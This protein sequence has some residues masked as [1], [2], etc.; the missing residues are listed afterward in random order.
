MVPFKIEFNVLKARSTVKARARDTPRPFDF[1]GTCRK[2]PDG[3][4][5]RLELDC[6]R[7]KRCTVPDFSNEIFTTCIV[8]T[9]ITG[10]GEDITAITS[11]TGIY[12]SNRE[13]ALLQDLVDKDTL[14]DR[15]NAT[16]T[17]HLTE[18]C[19]E[20]LASC[21]VHDVI[22]NVGFL[23]AS[24]HKVHLLQYIALLKRIKAFLT[25]NPKCRKCLKAST[26][27]V[28]SAIR[29]I[30]GTAI[31]KQ[32]ILTDISLD[33]LAARKDFNPLNFALLG[34]EVARQDQLRKDRVQVE[35]VHAYNVDPA[36]ILL[37]E[38]RPT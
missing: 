4:A 7:C 15:V 1:K 26:R 21:M 19:R 17:R 36:G 18:G 9:V 29:A 22:G 2:M 3:A 6:T 25:H 20:G 13:I 23:S 32:V 12:L 34:V 14:L 38:I 31:M 28:T 37:A 33:D 30:E 11:D 27:L 8:N 5:W 10:S 35:P 16:I 24:Y